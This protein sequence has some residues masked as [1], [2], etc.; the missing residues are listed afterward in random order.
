LDKF[1]IIHLFYFYLEHKL[2]L[3][4]K[5]FVVCEKLGLSAQLINKSFVT[6]FL[7]NRGKYQ[8]LIQILNKKL[9]LPA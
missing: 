7:P 8:F 2:G 1:V 5:D 6:D 4:I 9:T 3:I